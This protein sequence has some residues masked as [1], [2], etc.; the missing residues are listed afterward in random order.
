MRTPRYEAAKKRSSSFMASMVC[1]ISAVLN[2]DYDKSKMGYVQCSV[3]LAT[4]V[5]EGL[6]L[7]E[8]LDGDDGVVH[9]KP[10]SKEQRAK[11]AISHREREKFVMFRLS[12]SQSQSSSSTPLPVTQAR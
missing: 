5:R 4:L 12:P 7:V 9:L 11:V 6:P 2:D 3:A 8:I 1:L 10:K